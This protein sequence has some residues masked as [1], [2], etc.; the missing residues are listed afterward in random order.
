VVPVTVCPTVRRL[1]G[2]ALLVDH[3]V[4]RPADV[5]VVERR[6]SGTHGDI[7]GPIAGVDLYEVPLPRVSLV[8]PQDRLGRLVDERAVQLAPIHLVEEVVQVGVD[9]YF[10]AVDEV[11]PVVSVAWS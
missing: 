7:P 2:H 6:N 10:D 5:D 11:G 3:V 9:V 1:L 4:D 8:A